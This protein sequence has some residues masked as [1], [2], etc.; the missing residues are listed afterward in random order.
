MSGSS[1]STG[2]QEPIP[3]KEPHQPQHTGSGEGAQSAFTRMK[4]ER[5]HHE[6]VRPLDDAQGTAS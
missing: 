5:D 6:R 4:Q 3:N 2:G 1:K